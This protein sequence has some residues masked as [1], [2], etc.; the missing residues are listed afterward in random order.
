MASARPALFV[1]PARCESADA[2]RDAGCG[3]IVDPESEP[4]EAAQ[5]LAYTLREWSADTQRC[6]AMGERG[7]RAFLEQYERDENCAA[8]ARVLST[9]WGHAHASESAGAG[10]ETDVLMGHSV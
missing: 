9:A 1:G 6:R 8:W 10:R 7:R 5:R 3:A 4:G 2:I